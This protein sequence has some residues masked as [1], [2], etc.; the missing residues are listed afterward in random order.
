MKTQAQQ[1]LKEFKSPH[2]FGD[3]VYTIEE[4]KI[5]EYEVYK[6]T[7]CD[8]ERDEYGNECSRF[9]GGYDIE[10]GIRRWDKTKGLMI[11][12]Y[13]GKNDIGKTHFWSKQKLLESL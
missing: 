4:N 10:F 13:I 8:Y 11:T 2:G 5:Q 3:K 9:R 12:R 7:F 6:I 1:E